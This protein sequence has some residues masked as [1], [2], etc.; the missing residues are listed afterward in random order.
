M[1]WFKSHVGLRHN[2]IY[3]RMS[4]DARNAF[5]NAMRA[6]ADYEQN[7]ALATRIGP[8]NDEELAHDLIVSERKL[9]AVLTE[10][11]AAGLLVRDESGVIFVAKFEEKTESHA[12]RQKRWR[13]KKRREREQAEHENTVDG[14]RVTPSSD[15]PRDGNGESHADIS[16][17]DTTN[18]TDIEEERREKNIVPNGTS[19]DAERKVTPIR[20]KAPKPEHL[21]MD[22]LLP[23]ILKF[24]HDIGVTQK[25]WRAR[26]AGPTK[27]LL[28][29]GKTAE[30]IVAML[31]VA[32]YHPE[33]TY[34]RHID[35]IHK[36]AE[37]W[38]ALSRIANGKARREAE[39]LDAAVGLRRV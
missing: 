11:F 3:R 32:L 21:A 36:L 19:A 31:R 28:D 7:G 23:V 10:L 13:D 2:P 4:A 16:T 38:S 34:Y 18:V 9:P 26:N 22:L 29:G 39:E 27:A 5:D 17:R 14:S 1:Q 12:A 20:E 33:A 6:A 15:S 25:A 37:K 8:L 35:S 24:G 30:E